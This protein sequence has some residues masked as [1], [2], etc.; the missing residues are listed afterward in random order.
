MMALS[1]SFYM[2]DV[3]KKSQSAL[4]L[5]DKSRTALQDVFQVRL[6]LRV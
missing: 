2:T 4:S 6:S 1:R 5:D 3:A